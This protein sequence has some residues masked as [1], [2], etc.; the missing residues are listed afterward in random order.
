MSPEELAK[1]RE[2]LNGV[3]SVFGML[4]VAR[5]AREFPWGRIEENVRRE[6]DAKLDALDKGLQRVKPK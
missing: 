4:T 3:H 6:V 5:L 1:V 2:A